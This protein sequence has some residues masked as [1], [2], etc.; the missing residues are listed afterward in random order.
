MQQLGRDYE[1]IHVGVHS[2]SASHWFKV[3]GQWLS[4]E[5]FRSAELQNI[6]QHCHF[7]NLWACSNARYTAPGCMGSQYVFSNT[8]G[9]LAIGTTK[10]GGMIGPDDFYSPLSLNV[11]IGN[12]FQEWFTDIGQNNRNWTYGMVMLG[13]PTLTTHHDLHAIS[14]NVTSPSHPDP[15]DVY[16]NSTATFEWETPRDMTGIAGYYYRIDRNPTTVP[17]PTASTWTEG[18]NASFSSLT[19]GLWYFHIVSVD[20][21]GNIAKV[22]THFQIELDTTPPT[23]SIVVN[24]G[25]LYTTD[26]N[27]SLDIEAEDKGG[28]V[29][30]RFS[31][32]DATWGDWNP[33]NSTH[34][35]E[36][37]PGDGV[38]TVYAQVMDVAELVSTME[39]SDS[40]ILD[41]TPPEGTIS[42]RSSKGYVTSPDL[43]VDVTGTDANGVVRM[44]FSDDGEIWGAWKPF[45]ESGRWAVPAED[46]TKVVYLQLE[47]EAGLISTGVSS[48]PV[49]LDTT[50]P[51]V[52]F[53]I[54]G[55][56]EF[57][58]RTTIHLQIEAVDV[59][60]VD[61]IRY[62]L[63]G[64]EW[65]EWE[66][67]TTSMDLELPAIEGPWTVSIQV[68]DR[69]GLLS[70]NRTSDSIILDMTPPSCEVQIDG[71]AKYTTR[72]GVRVTIEAS[73]LNGL[74]ELMYHLDGAVVG[75]SFPYIEGF[76]LT[77]DGG[78][79]LYTVRITVSDNAGLISEEASA[80]IVLDTMPPSGT[81]SFQGPE[82]RYTASPTIELILTEYEEGD[83]VEM[84]FRTN[85]GVWSEWEPFM[86]SRSFTLGPDEGIQTVFVRYRDRAGLI[87][88]DPLRL[89]VHLDTVNPLLELSLE[90]SDWYT[91]ETDITIGTTGSSEPGGSP[92]TTLGVSYDGGMTWYDRA[93]GDTMTF[94]RTVA[95]EWDKVPVGANPIH[96]RL[97]DKVGNTD[98]EDITV[99]KDHLDPELELPMERHTAVIPEFV[100]MW[101][102]W[103]NESGIES[104]ELYLDGEGPVDVT[105]MV[106]YRWTDLMNGEHTVRLVAT[107]VAGNTVT[108]TAKVDVD[109]GIFNTEGA[110]TTVALLLLVVVG[111]VAVGLWYRH[112]RR[113]RN[114]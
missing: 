58:T 4:S 45:A 108:R 33:V 73:D 23:G 1:W 43:I 112:S 29:A 87:T 72:Q 113:V 99:R 71:G 50:P 59:N 91:E 92:L 18:N 94:E 55:D 68:R 95:L 90:G 98:I 37:P 74:D 51:E 56:A 114:G 13:D 79:G 40:I 97:I 16:S 85:G 86:T 83:A 84:S 64:G 27:V 52:S 48:E 96:L 7:V 2:G 8:Y 63:I 41:T 21:V 49:V 24:S 100:V 9:L 46:G 47:D 39:I 3:D 66:N 70:Q 88:L 60:P 89:P 80:S 107:D 34:D 11:T 93:I 44:R 101:E 81:V 32:D 76:N 31:T 14:P 67:F 75:G 22:P 12:A 20:V 36:L 15:S 78:D 109:A 26:L 82:G 65:S 5:I 77:L 111:L 53:F 105:G 10:T 25:D 57:T 19:E 102:C 6:D 30:M 17:I 103:D 62:M 35:L 54:N 28:V 61:G 110:W 38:K 42:V 106:S 69:A 104:I